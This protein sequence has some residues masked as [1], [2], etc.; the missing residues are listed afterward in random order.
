MS[1]WVMRVL[2]VLLVTVLFG[3]ILPLGSITASAAST[4]VT[5]TQ[6]QTVAQI[7]TAIENAINALKNGGTVTVLGSKTNVDREVELNIPANVTVIWK[8]KYNMTSSL[9]YTLVV[10]CEYGG[11]FEVAE[12]GEISTISDYAISD[13]GVGDIVISGGTVSVDKDGGTAIHIA[14]G[15]VKVTGGMVSANGSSSRAIY[16]SVVGD[17][18]ITGGIVRA[19]GTGARAI[20]AWFYNSYAVYLAGTTEGTVSATN[21]MVVEVDSLS[22]PAS[23]DGTSDGLTIKAGS[24]TAVW[25]YSGDMPTIIL[26]LNSSIYTR[27]IVWGNRLEVD[28]NLRAT[29]PEEAIKLNINWSDAFFAKKATIVNNDLAIASLV[30]SNAAY[31]QTRITNTLTKLGFSDIKPYA[32]GM[33]NWDNVGHTISHNTTGT[34]TVIAIVIRGTPPNVKSISEWGNNVLTRFEQASVNIWNDLQTYLE[35]FD[36]N[37]NIKFWITGHSRGG[38]VANILGERITRSNLG[39]QNTVYVYTFASPNTTTDAK[40]AAN[41]NSFNIKNTED[42][43]VCYF[44]STYTAMTG[45]GI[46]TY[47]APATVYGYPLWYTPNAAVESQFL[48]LTGVSYKT[49]SPHL[50]EAYLAILLQ[51][52]TLTPNE[53]KNGIRVFSIKCPVDVEIYDNGNN[54]IGKIINNEIIFCVES[55]T[56]IWLEDDEKY[57]TSPFDEKYTVKLTGTDTGIMTYIVEDVDVVSATVTGQ[58]EFKNVKLSAGKTMVSTA[59]ATVTTPHVQ[60]LVTNNE[61]VPIATVNTDGTETAISQSANKTALNAKI[62]EAESKVNDAQYTDTSRAALRTAIN[63]AKAVANNTNATQAEVD[64]AATELNNAINGLVKANGIFGTNA[65]WYGAWWHYILFFLCFGFIWM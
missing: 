4:N 61:G 12:G 45:I 38:A 41:G 11:I 51:S 5:I 56:L 16:I 65:K 23:R 10:C 60:L 39:N 8:A 50:P 59:G 27:E 48:Q 3:G 64:A 43:P 49:I 55:K 47:Q 20:S 52:R 46:T 62:N 34:D 53:P 35:R 58:K 25:D 13:S 7:Q 22:I 31:D 42:K 1:K 2:S 37:Q 21:G 33:W 28:F 15:T 63:S 19:T 24:G 14:S 18:T 6:S 32:Y 44:P 29:D 9:S 30:L 26:K 57:F 40:M 17:A 36:N 54:L